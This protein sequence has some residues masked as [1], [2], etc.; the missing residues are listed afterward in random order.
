MTDGKLAPIKAEVDI[1]APIAHVWTILTTPEHAA[2]WL[3][4]LNF[5]ATV[6]HTFHMQPDTAKR[7]AG[8]ITGATWCDVEQLDEPNMMVFS[9]YMPDTPKTNVE[10]R[11]SAIN[12]QNTRVS[13]V[14]DGWDQFPVEFVASI[15]QA[16]SGGWSGHVLPNLRRA[17]EE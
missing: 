10:F 3:G 6:G 11:L 1:A 12:G 15:H 8:D 5:A 13:L 17:C 2:G 9:W 14:H 16:L 7:Q 4:C